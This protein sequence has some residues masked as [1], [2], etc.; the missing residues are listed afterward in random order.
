MSVNNSSFSD[1]VVK[2]TEAAPGFGRELALQLADH[3]VWL[4]QIAVRGVCACNRNNATS[5]PTPGES[6]SAAVDVETRW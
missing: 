3:E 6:T 2:V 1:K 4:A 5:I